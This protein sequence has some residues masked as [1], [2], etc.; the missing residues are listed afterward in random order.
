MPYS[1]DKHFQKL[2]TWIEMES[3]AERLRL[4]E[5]RKNRSQANVESRGETLIDLVIADDRMG[6][7]GRYLATFVKRNRTLGLPWNRFRVGSP[8]IAFDELNEQD[9]GYGIVSR[10]STTSLEVAFDEPID[11]ERFRL[12]LSSDEITRNR[13]LLALKIV[14]QARE[15]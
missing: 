8:V 9:C 13:Q 14:E 5:R 12:D 2:R 6:L 7:G 1:A 10:R 11:G 15:E 3:E 4:Q